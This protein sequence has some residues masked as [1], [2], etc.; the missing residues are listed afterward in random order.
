M[1][2]LDDFIMPVS[3]SLISSVV[4]AVLLAATNAFGEAPSFRHDVLPV[5]TKA[6]CNS[7]ACHGT[8]TGKN[9]FRLSLRGYHA[10]LDLITLVR[11]A[12]GRRINLADPDQSLLLLKATNQTP[13]QGGARMT[14]DS[15]SYRILRDWIAAG[16]SDDPSERATLVAVGV[17][18]GTA[19]VN[20]PQHA[21]RLRV[22]ARFSNGQVRDVT[23]LARYSV[24]DESVATINDGGVVAKLK[25]GEAIVSAEYCNQ[26]ASAKVTFLEP[27]A[28]F[29]WPD[30]IEHNAIDRLLFEKLRRLSIEPS[31][32]SSDSDFVRRVYLDVIGKLP[33]AAET[34]TFLASNDPDKRS[35]LIDELL[36]RPGFADCWSA[37]WAD[38]LGCNRRFAGK[39][40][41]PKYHLWIRHAIATNLPEDEFVRQI[42]TAGGP[43]YS[44]PA[45]TFWRRLR[46]GAI[47]PEID[48][49]MAAEEVSQLF[50]G[51]R[52]QCARCH[53]HPQ[54][55]WTQE[56]F[57]GL[58]A[59]FTRL[60]FKDGPFFNN[61]YDK[62]EAVYLAKPLELKH[63]RTGEDVLPKV[64]DGQPQ[65]FD[66]HDDPR[67]AFANW[68]TAAE[69]P[70]F[71]R[72][73]A[74]R[75]WYHLFGRGLVEPVDDIRTSNP[76]SHE[77]VLALLAREL[78]EHDFDR[79]HLIRM[80]A[81]SRTY[82]LSSAATATNADDN[83]Y[84]S[85]STIRL[86]S[87]EAL[88]DAICQVTGVP[89]KFPELPLG[90]TAMTL[91][92]G[93]Y[94]H[95]FLEA[96]GRPVRSSACECERDTQTNLSQALQLV[97]GQV[98][99]TK[100]ASG[101][102]RV[103]ELS[104][105]E[106][107][108]QETLDELFLSALSRYPTSEECAALTPKLNVAAPQRRQAI[109]DL[110]WILVNH[111]EFLFQH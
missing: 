53:N 98:V 39:A 76:A 43:N 61:R 86:L 106:I 84:F 33:T 36:E 11:E 91:P 77:E 59:F 92:D 73:S 56:D 1:T 17:T 81:N 80:V 41:A 102:G 42:L 65:R 27:V 28:E 46:V 26:F 20:A 6:G 103:A 45:A 90:A 31:P 22:E 4:L 32:L 70:F 24:H 99:Q 44:A 2:R 57:F 96:F 13:H 38:R 101:S 63:P 47:R 79:K 71:A 50:L 35:K 68:L 108:P 105:R 75:I 100:L 23:H 67:V 16:A 18:P 3:A 60:R 14:T 19:D 54:E 85:R 55:R 111:N 8:P 48:P 7:G 87:S 9:G 109:E 94:K 110:L 88:L 52:I 72:M 25:R 10:E 62:E 34:R 82:Q 78:V 95:P 107:S 104:T 64:L 51:V 74:N 15:G 40:G 97:S 93:E 30:P 69:N 29:R 5:L 66:E 83:R 89:E 37:R 49:L 12:E 58:A 21:Q